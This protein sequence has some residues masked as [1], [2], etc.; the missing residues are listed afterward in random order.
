[1]EAS[2]MHV[3]LDIKDEFKRK[4]MDNAGVAAA[5]HKDKSVVDRQFAE[6]NGS[7][8][9]LTG[10]GYAEAA[11]GRII[12]MLDEEWDRLQ[13][14]AQELSA[15]MDALR[16]REQRLG[17]LSETVN[18]LTLQNDAKDKLIERLEQRLDEKENSIKR[19][20]EALVLKDKRISD[21]T[22]RLLDGGK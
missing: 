21:L 7:Q 18:T 12:F 22:D 20:E 2:K 16:D 1:M 6:K 17:N 3:M 15:A 8:T 9:L 4:G 13:R 10:Y 14:L 19:K 11:G 5:T